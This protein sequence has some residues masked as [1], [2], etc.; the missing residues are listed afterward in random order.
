ML[1]F[2]KLRTKWIIAEQDYICT[3]NKILGANLYVCGK[4]LK[5]V[6]GEHEKSRDH[7]DF[8]QD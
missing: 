5:R 7:D 2:W 6:G 4:I 8:I 3:F 1:V